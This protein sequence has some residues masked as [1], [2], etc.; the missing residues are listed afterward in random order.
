MLVSRWFPAE[1]RAQCLLFL[2]FNFFLSFCPTCRFTKLE[3]FVRRLECG[4]L[5]ILMRLHKIR[6]VVTPAF[7]SA[8]CT[9]YFILEQK[10]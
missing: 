7:T 1:M 2:S 10:L 5:T 9:R 3:S 8:V 6:H 4:K